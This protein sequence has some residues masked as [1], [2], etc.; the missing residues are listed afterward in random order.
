[1]S[2]TRTYRS[3]KE[4]WRRCTNP[5]SENFRWYGGKGVTVCE[6]WG[7][8][9]QFF[10]DMGERPPERTLDRID[11]DGN[12]ELSNCRWATQEQQTK[13]NRGV[14][15]KGQNGRQGRSVIS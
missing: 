9:E 13:T 12:Y 11:S 2:K 5:N 3:W 14:F 15:K 10:A 6:E 8:F 7:S 4:M 1:M